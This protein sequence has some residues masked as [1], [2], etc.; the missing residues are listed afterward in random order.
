MK[1]YDLPPKEAVTLTIVPSTV[2]RS[3]NATLKG[4]TLQSVD[5]SLEEAVAI[6][7][8]Y[9]YVHAVDGVNRL[10]TQAVRYDAKRRP[11]QIVGV[12][13]TKQKSC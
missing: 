13:F 12:A 8:F 5:Y 4:F 9:G 6:D 11:T 1:I 3:G 7:G 2:T 10:G